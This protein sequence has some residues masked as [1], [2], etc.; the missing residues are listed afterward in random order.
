[1]HL[2][3]GRF[4]IRRDKIGEDG[5]EALEAA[6]IG[7]I[8]NKEAGCRG[9]G[10]GVDFGSAKHL[11]EEEERFAAGSG[12][13]V[14]HAVVL[15]GCESAGGQDGG[16]IEA[17]QQRE[18]GEGSLRGLALRRAVELDCRCSTCERRG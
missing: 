8:G 6:F 10:V 9:V 16:K 14:K 11:V 3:V 4:D 18:A 7:F 13:G 2:E 1:M 5:F 15:L 12:T 17:V